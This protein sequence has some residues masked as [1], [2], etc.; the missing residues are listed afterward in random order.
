MNTQT[1]WADVRESLR[2]LEASFD[3]LRDAVANKDGFDI[4]R[5]VFSDLR[6]SNEHH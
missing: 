5:D 4:F 1:T 6:K 2:A 3:K